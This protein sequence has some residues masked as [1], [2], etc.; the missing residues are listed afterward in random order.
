MAYWRGAHENVARR[1]VALAVC[2]PAWLLRQLLQQ[3]R[4]DNRRAVKSSRSINIVLRG[5]KQRRNVSRALGPRRSLA[6]A[7]YNRRGILASLL[8]NHPEQISIETIAA[9]QSLK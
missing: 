6:M 9:G 5:E 2:R 1:A 7:T 8:E 3:A 4:S